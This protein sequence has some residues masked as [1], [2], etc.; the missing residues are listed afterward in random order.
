MVGVSPRKGGAGL[1]AYMKAALELSVPSELHAN[2]FVKQQAHK[3]EGLRHRAAFVPGVGH[4]DDAISCT[5]LRVSFGGMA[6]LG[7][8]LLVRISWNWGQC[9]TARGKQGRQALGGGRWALI[10]QQMA[11]GAR[12]TIQ[13]EACVN[14]LG[15]FCPASPPARFVEQAPRYHHHTQSHKHL[16]TDTGP[17][18]EVS[19]V[20]TKGA[21]PKRAMACIMTL[22]VFSVLGETMCA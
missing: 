5:F 15:Q 14:G 12:P 1:S 11:G 4:G 9:A 19:R 13:P 21:P 6:G 20:T 22:H 3:V 17:T 10:F 16:A 2:H 18:E 7:A 8:L